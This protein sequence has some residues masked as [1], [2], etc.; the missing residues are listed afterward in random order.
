MTGISYLCDTRP[1]QR[2]NTDTILGQL[3]VKAKDYLTRFRVEKELNESDL[4]SYIKQFY[5]H[6]AQH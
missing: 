1:A 3:P 2:R 6:S 5:I 4:R